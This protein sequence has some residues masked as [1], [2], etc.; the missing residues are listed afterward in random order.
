MTLYGS[1]L[2]QLLD[3]RAA[4]HPN[5]PAILAPGRAPLT[6][7]GLARQVHETRDRLD[8]LGISGGDRVAIVLGNGPE[9]ATAFLGVAACAVS[10][11]LNPSYRAEEVQF[12]LSD[13]QAKALIVQQGQE[14]PARAVAH[15][16]GVTIIELAP[17]TEKAAGLFTLHGKAAARPTV[18]VPVVADDIALILHTSGT[19]SRPKMVPLTHRNLLASA[20]NVARSLQLSPDD[21]C[22]NVM[23]LFHIHG[24]VAALLA[25]LSAGGSVVCTPGFDAVAFFDWLRV[26]EPTWYS[27]VPTMHQAILA[28]VPQ[29]QADLA[30]RPLRFVRSSSASLPPPVMAQ[31]ERA[32]AA[33]VIEAYG[34]TEA[35]HQMA[36]NPLPPLVRKPGSVGPATGP[37][38]AVMH[39][40][41]PHLLPT[42]ERGEV[43]IR[44]E[45]VMSGYVNNPA[46]N[47]SAF[48]AGWFRTGDQGYL[49]LDGYL[50]ITGRLKEIINRGGEKVSPRE[51]D[52]AFLSHPAVAQAV[53]FAV[54]HPTL[55]EDVAA[56]VVLRPEASA[57]V[58]DLRE[59][60]FERLAD[61]KVPSQ[62]VI[63]N[64][65]PKGPTGKLQ[66]IGLHEKL[67]DQLRSEYVAPRDEIEQV[68]A[69]M[70][71][72]VLGVSRI[73][74]FDNFFVLGGDSLSAARL[75]NRINEEFQ[76]QMPLSGVFQKPTVAGH[77]YLLV[78]TVASSEEDVLQN[79]VNGGDVEH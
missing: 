21:R 24:L 48:A 46:A 32:F 60:A 56:A 54:P 64:Q 72:D 49:D 57:T 1:T 43:V 63:V 37:E 74:A 59:H 36:S 25:S 47:A 67:A 2:I 51:V 22:L 13:L 33:P 65:I 10:A 4:G 53:A 12:Y 69:A 39:P 3:N 38:I 29:H 23:P 40:D 73:G 16:L 71:M 68:I 44:G 6:Y 11:P 79:M 18:A 9:M 30:W 77:A 58:E 8:V 50:T 61:F 17:Q 45:N 19:T 75:V 20:V 27:A 31:L 55:G 5:A 78:E 35:A 41:D 26:S 62:V 76:V 42:G 66:R 70:W 28:N 14:T 34:M 15:A 7:S 52:E